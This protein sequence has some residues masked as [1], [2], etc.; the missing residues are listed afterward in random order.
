MRGRV[1]WMAVALGMVLGVGV[2]ASAEIYLWTDERGMVHMTNQWA[3]V[4]E[5]ARAHVSVRESTPPSRADTPAVEPT[6]HSI[7]SVTIRQPPL[8][9]SPDLAPTPPTGAPSPAVVPYPHEPSGLILSSR[10]FVRHRRKIAPPF[11]YN[12][13][14]D[15]FDP[16]FVWVGRNRVPK[17]SFTYPRVSLDTQAQFRNR[18]RALERRP[19]GPQKTLPAMPA[20]R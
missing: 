7:D 19:S 12:V 18:L 1:F 3:S 16:N 15:P 4:P 13:R 6:T 5:S 14:P 8:Q 2:E 11:P 9:M 10:S 17:D 20:R